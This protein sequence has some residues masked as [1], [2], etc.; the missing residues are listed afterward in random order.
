MKINTEQNLAK[1]LTS[2]TYP[3]ATAIDVKLYDI[4]SERDG[5]EWNGRKTNKWTPEAQIDWTCR[6]HLYLMAY[7][8]HTYFATSW[9]YSSKPNIENKNTD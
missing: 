8:D 4:M 3:L 6:L 9:T 2:L 1:I 5:K 7:K